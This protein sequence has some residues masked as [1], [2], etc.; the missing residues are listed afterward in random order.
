MLATAPET[1]ISICVS[2]YFGNLSVPS[3]HTFPARTFATIAN[4]SYV[5]ILVTPSKLKP[6]P[7]RLCL[8]VL[9][10]TDRPGVEILPLAEVSHN[11]QNNS[12]QQ[13]TRLSQSCITN[14]E[15]WSSR[16]REIHSLGK[17]RNGDERCVSVKCAGE[18]AVEGQTRGE[19]MHST[20]EFPRNPTG[21]K[22]N[23]RGSACRPGGS[24]ARKSTKTTTTTTRVSS[25]LRKKANNNMKL[26]IKI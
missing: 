24:S 5:H 19:K 18:A 9:I 4:I 22:V 3:N 26:D 20:P 25:R 17:D 16:K 21:R 6:S 10:T 13:R 1:G 11:Q 12:G 8:R 7:S 14:Q 23:E 2:M 15:P